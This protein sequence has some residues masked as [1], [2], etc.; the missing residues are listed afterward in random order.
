MRPRMTR[1][2]SSFY[3]EREFYFIFFKQDNKV[4]NSIKK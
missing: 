1:I 4:C 3:D 2:N